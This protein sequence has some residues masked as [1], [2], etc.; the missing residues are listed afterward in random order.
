VVLLLHTTAT[1]LPVSLPGAKLESEQ[2]QKI[3]QEASV[4]A[5]IESLGGAI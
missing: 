5:E 3:E 4:I 1:L 2:L